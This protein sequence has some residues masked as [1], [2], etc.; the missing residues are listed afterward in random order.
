MGPEQQTIDP[1]Q[2]TPIG[3]IPTED[4][5]ALPTLNPADSPYTPLDLPPVEA[6]QV[7]LPEASPEPQNLGAVSRGGAIAYMADKILRGAMQGYDFAQQ[8][9][10]DQFNKKLA[11]QQSIYNDQAKQL[12]D[13]AVA[14]VDPNSQEFKDARNR[15]LTAWQATMQTIGERIPQPKQSKKSKQG[16][17]NGQDQSNLLARALNHQ[18]DPQD[19]LQAVYQGAVATGP[20]VFHQI[21]PYLTPQYQQQQRQKAQGEAATLTAGTT[22]AELAEQTAKHKQN[23]LDLTTK[24]NQTTDQQQRDKIQGQIDAETDALSAL[25]GRNASV[26][27]ITGAAG[28]PIEYPAGSGKYARPVQNASGETV[29][30][31]MPEGWKP[32]PPKAATSQWAQGLDAYAKSHNADP[33]DWQTIRAYEQESYSAKNPLAERRLALA[34]RNTAIAEKRVELSQQGNDWRALQNIYKQ[35]A[36]NIAIQATAQSS[37]EYTKNPTGPGDVALTLAF[38]EVAKAADPGSGS[39]IRFTQQEQKLIQGARGWADAAQANVERWGKGTLYDAA[40]RATMAKI[41]KDAAK[42]SNEAT[43]SY[44]GAAAKINPR[45]TAAATGGAAPSVTTYKHTATGPNNHK[46]GTNDDPYSAT[47]K[48]YD[49]STGKPVQ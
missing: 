26:R 44:L 27:P 15:V 33:N 23:I 47:A 11:A 31:P 9:K 42:S 39:G 29:M 17:A 8:Q 38:F 2:A 35:T 3:R 13:M 36:P 21:A 12:H 41:I 4:T 34:D 5:P 49:V 24:L 32:A 48:W 22:N 37:D 7:P 46:I 10:A 30:E 19:A 1:T 43:A 16:Q 40:Q 18:N 20:P 14:G 28:Q 25:S 6:K 45:A